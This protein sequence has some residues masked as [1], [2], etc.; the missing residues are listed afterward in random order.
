MAITKADLIE[1]LNRRLG[2]SK[3]EGKDLVEA[4]FEQITSTLAL[5]EEVKLSGFG[6]FNVRQKGERPGR[7]PKTGEEIPITPRRVISFRVSQKL[8]DALDLR[9][10]AGPQ[11]ETATRADAPDD[12]QTATRAD[13]RTDVRANTRAKA[14]G[15]TQGDREDAGTTPG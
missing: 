6:Q 4:F 8:R 9:P 7:N 14:R 12:A 5:G 10:Q 1:H 15:M 2:L 13:T 11:V 3:R